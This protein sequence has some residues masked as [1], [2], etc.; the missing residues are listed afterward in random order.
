MTVHAPPCA[1]L[2]H[3]LR[4]KSWGWGYEPRPTAEDLEFDEAG[5]LPCQGMSMAATVGRDAKTG[6]DK[7]QGVCVQVRVFPR[8]AWPW[9]LRQDNRTL[10]RLVAALAVTSAAVMVVPS[11]ASATTSGDVE[12]I[13]IVTNSLNP[14]GTIIIRGPYVD[15]GTAHSRTHRDR[16]VFAA[17]SFTIYRPGGNFAF[18]LRP[19]TCI[20]HI[21]GTGDYTIG[22]GAGVYEGVTGRG[23][24]VFQ[25][26]LTLG[27]NP[28]GTCDQDSPPIAEQD[29]FEGKGSMSL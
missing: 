16:A 20:A 9:D 13:R 25:G 18:S 8:R 6:Q 29:I 11:L 22:N 28:D 23:T 21:T 10:P 7:Q 26:L 12:R 1:D 4:P 5:R 3:R 24:Y 27:R 19:K 14:A 2:L 17:G 15:G